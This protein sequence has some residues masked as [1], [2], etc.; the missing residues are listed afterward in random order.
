MRCSRVEELVLNRHEP[1]LAEIGRCI[2][3][4]GDGNRELG[5]SSR[6]C[7]GKRIEQ[8]VDHIHLQVRN[9]SHEENT[10]DVLQS[11]IAGMQG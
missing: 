9:G 7:G 4:R 2:K 10:N 1:A 8:V 6:H 3:R 5:H 11:I